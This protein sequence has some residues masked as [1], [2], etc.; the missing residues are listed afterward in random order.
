MTNKE[1]Y[2]ALFQKVNGPAS[3][4][5]TDFRLYFTKEHPTLQQAFVRHLIYPALTILAKQRPDMRNQDSHDFAVKA[6]GT[7]P[8]YFRTI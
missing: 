7:D 6:L 3:S 4:F 1:L 5:E 8:I 2:D